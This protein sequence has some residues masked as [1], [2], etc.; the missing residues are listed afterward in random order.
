MGRLAK[1]DIPVFLLYGNHDAESQ[2][3]K[4][5]SLPENVHVFP[6]RK[7]QTFE[8]EGHRVALHGHS[9]RQ[10]DVT[11]NL[12]PAYPAPIDGSFNIGV[13]HT[14]LGGMG[15]HANYAPC[16][17]NEDRKSTRLNSSH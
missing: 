6:S 16:D 3:T 5:L 10:R 15:G 12:V 7:P 9:Y 1:A 4:R 2:I 17:I 11:D 8:I 14:G 13:L